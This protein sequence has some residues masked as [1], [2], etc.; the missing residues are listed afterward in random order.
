[1]KFNKFVNEIKAIAL[2][3]GANNKKNRKNF[4][5]FIIYSLRDPYEHVLISLYQ[6]FEYYLFIYLFN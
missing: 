5:E 1:M 6:D 4:D 2:L 3:E